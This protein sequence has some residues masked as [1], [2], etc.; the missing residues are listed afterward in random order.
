VCWSEPRGVP[1][2]AYDDGRYASLSLKASQDWHEALE[3]MLNEEY[4]LE[5]VNISPVE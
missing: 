2:P 1:R 4:V 5:V 3:L